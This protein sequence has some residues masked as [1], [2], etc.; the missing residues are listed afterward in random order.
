VNSH[1]SNNIQIVVLLVSG[2][3]GGEQMSV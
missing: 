2:G 1:V 3:V